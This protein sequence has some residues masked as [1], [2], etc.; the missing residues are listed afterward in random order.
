MQY[1]LIAVP[2]CFR[3]V[4]FDLEAEQRF[5]KRKVSPNRAT[6]IVSSPDVGELKI[7]F[8]ARFSQLLDLPGLK[9]Q[10]FMKEFI[11][12]TLTLIAKWRDYL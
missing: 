11:F 3:M 1:F 8:L 7:H 5:L 9:K 4:F 6:E 2:I 10:G 12:L